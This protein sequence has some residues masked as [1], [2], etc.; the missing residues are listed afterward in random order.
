MKGG[1]IAAALLGSAWLA[2]CGHASSDEGAPQPLRVHR[3]G[4]N[5]VVVVDTSGEMA[6]ERLARARAGLDELVRAL[7]ARDHV[8]LA[9]FSEQLEPLLPVEGARSN[10][11]RLRAAVASLEAGG[12][13]A[14]YD[15]TLQ[16]YGIQ[17]ELAGGRHL[18]TVVVLAHGEDSASRSS[19][20]RVRRLL[21][22]QGSGVRVRVFTIAYDTDPD[23]GV[24]QALHAFASVSGG[25]SYR[26]S[27]A[28]VDT[29]LRR[30]WQAL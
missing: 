22:A 11:R 9:R 7:P 16:A 17:R 18:N 14:V 6:G 19:Y 10:R 23:A 25:R 24:R 20:G 13:S 2:G 12:H 3:A 15:A 8:G 30:V 26:A 1:A 4:A 29:V 21:G 28:D 27:P 5:V